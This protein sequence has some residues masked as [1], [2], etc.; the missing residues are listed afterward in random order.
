MLPPGHIAGGYLTGK[1]GALFIPALN[2]PE[3]L[4]L[5]A[6]FGFVPD[7]DFF[8]AF[9]KTKKFVITEEETNHHLYITH[10][11]IFYIAIFILWLIIFPESELYAYT[12]I[13]GTLSH[14]LIDTFASDG[15][16]WLYPF[17]KKL[18]GIKL[19]QPIRI[20]NE[21]FWQHWTLFVKE[22]FKL[23]SFRLELI[24]IVLALITFYW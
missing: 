19:D 13:L 7:L 14:L 8:F 4:V 6:F 21:N 16:L 5:T 15:T 2:T 22:Y 18:Y 10:A 1:L 12:F 17:S 23:K 9:G 3:L 24:L 20:K 11:P